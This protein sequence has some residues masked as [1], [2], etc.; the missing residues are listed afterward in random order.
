MILP[1]PTK[2][3]FKQTTPG[4]NMKTILPLFLSV[5][6]SAIAADEIY[7]AKFTTLNPQ[8][9]GVLSG[10]ATL[11]LKDKTI[12][13]YSR[14]FS[15]YPKAWH[16][17]NVF[18]GNR[19]PDQ[20]DDQNGDGVI[21]INEAQA[22]VGKILIPLDGNLSSQLSGGDVFPIADDFGSY[23]YEQE[24]SYSAFLKDL[25]SKDPNPE[26]NVV[27]LE[28]YENL[29]ISGKAVLVQGVTDAASLPETSSTYGGRSHEQTF[30]IVCGIFKRVR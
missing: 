15:G 13:A 10:S 30:P 6:F 9:N 11:Y 14:H 17:Q 1:G 25:K 7:L 29:N 22:V 26:D 27:K 3:L 8:I 18:T 28:S 24:S 2:K 23:F 19:C 4:N 16:M 5:S 12:V 20:T 21:D